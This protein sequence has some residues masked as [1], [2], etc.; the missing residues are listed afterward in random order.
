MVLRIALVAGFAFSLQAFAGFT[1]PKLPRESRG[2]YSL[3]PVNTGAG[4]QTQSG[5]IFSLTIGFRRN[6]LTKIDKGH[7]HRDRAQEIVDK[8]SS[9]LANLKLDDVQITVG[10]LYATTRELIVNVHVD[11]PDRTEAVRAQLTEFLSKMPGVLFV[12]APTTMK[13]E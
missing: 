11:N 12:G 10:K 5:G 2:V 6:A 7:S 8:L 3:E 1:P 13:V 9:R 4:F